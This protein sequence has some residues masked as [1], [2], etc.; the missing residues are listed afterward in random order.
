[1][2]KNFK[3]TLLAYE[4]NTEELFMVLDAWQTLKMAQLEYF[5]QVQELLLKQVEY[6]KENEIK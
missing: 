1:L 4:Q 3:T 6:E 2:Q 5:N